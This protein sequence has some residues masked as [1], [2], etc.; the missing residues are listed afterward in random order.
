MQVKEQDASVLPETDLTCKTLGAVETSGA[1]EL[2]I[3]ASGERTV[4]LQ[5]QSMS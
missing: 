1:G 4:S 5:I 2:V 3:C